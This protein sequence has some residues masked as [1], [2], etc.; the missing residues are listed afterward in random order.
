MRRKG[1][2]PI[3]I[4]VRPATLYIVEVVE[5]LIRDKQQSRSWTTI[6]VKL[7]EAL[8]SETIFSVFYIF[9]ARYQKLTLAWPSMSDKRLDSS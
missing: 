3:Y 6:G 1:K 8:T 5:L 4:H 9:L 2:N 7:I